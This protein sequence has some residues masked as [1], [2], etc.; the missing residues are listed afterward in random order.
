[1]TISSENNNRSEKLM[2]SLFKNHLV[3]SRKK[4][5]TKTTTSSLEK[6]SE[7]DIKLT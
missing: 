3:P 7:H 4:K 1:M 6:R 5:L 2:I